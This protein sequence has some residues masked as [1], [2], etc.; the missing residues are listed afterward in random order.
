MLSRS[1]KV[2][3]PECNGSNFWKGDPKPTDELHCRFCDAFVA[4]YDGYIHDKIRHEAAQTL[5]KF[6]EADSEDDISMLKHALS[7][8]EHRIARTA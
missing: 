5:A 2:D 1:R 3:C 7:Y 8:P 4:T 6:I